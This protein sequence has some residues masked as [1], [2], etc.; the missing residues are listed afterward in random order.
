MIRKITL[1][2]AC[3]LLFACSEEKKADIPST[4]ISKQK[5]AE[6]MIDIHLLEATMNLNNYNIDRITNGNSSILYDVFKKHKIT[7]KE[8]RESFNYY[9]QHPEIL[10]EV[11]QLVLDNLSKMQAEVMNRKEV[12]K[13]KVDTVKIDTPKKE[14]KTN[15]LKKNKKRLAQITK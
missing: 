5:M 2:F 1:I 8:Y 11:Y 9:S 7:K 10:T 14:K 13:V 6:V 3:I 4:V 15:V 12:V